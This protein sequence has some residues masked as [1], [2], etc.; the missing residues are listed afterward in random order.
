MVTA[1]KRPERRTTRPD[2]ATCCDG[3]ARPAPRA[4]PR[5]PGCPWTGPRRPRPS[6]DPSWGA[7]LRFRRSARACASRP[8]ATPTSC[9]S[10]PVSRRPAWSWRRGSGPRAN[11]PSWPRRRGPRPTAR[12]P[13]ESWKPRSRP[14]PCASGLSGGCP[15][16]SPG[17]WPRCWPPEPRKPSARRRGRRRER[18]LGGRQRA[19]QSARPAAAGGR[20]HA[21]AGRL[22]LAG[23]RLG[24]PGRHSVRA[25]GPLGAAPGRDAAGGRRHPAVASAGAGRVVAARRVGHAAPAGGLVRDRQCR[26]AAP[27]P[28][29]EDPG[30]TIPSGRPGDR[31]ATARSTVELRERLAAAPWGDPG[32]ATARSVQLG[33]RLSWMAQ[34]GAELERA[35]P[36]AAGAAALLVARERFVAGHDLPAAALPRARRLLGPEALAATSLAEL[37]R[38]L[39]ARAHWAL[40]DVAAPE[41]LWHAE[42]KWWSR[43]ERDGFSLLGDA[44][45]GSAPVLGTVAVLATD[46]WRVRAALEVFDGLG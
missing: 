23:G 36:W 26:R 32:E 2:P 33:M 35:A 4:R 31:L 18:C 5:A 7:S 15:P 22:R 45:L 20:R 30:G 41:E 14:P 37:A 6:S 9:A 16:S 38:R 28:G 46:A 40:E 44:G 43:V 29:R 17:W 11:A 1:R 19:R 3:S 13:A 42:A 25:R 39:P 8:A 24:G 12:R 21:G 10:G 34:I 27:P